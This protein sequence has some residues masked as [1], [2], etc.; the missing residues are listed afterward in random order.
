M[1]ARFL[2]DG[3]LS[4]EEVSNFE[5]RTID[6]NDE[7]LNTNWHDDYTFNKVFDEL[8]KKHR[9]GIEISV[10]DY[11]DELIGTVTANAESVKYHYA[12][13]KY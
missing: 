3:D 5:I 4:L 8:R 12:V 2:K 10:L 1:M 9:S 7:V 11:G 13:I 6:E